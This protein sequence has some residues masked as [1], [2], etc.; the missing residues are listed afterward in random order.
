MKTRLNYLENA[1]ILKQSSKQAFLGFDE[2]Q[3][4]K[5]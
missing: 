4:E 3:R 1:A 5:Y 2:L